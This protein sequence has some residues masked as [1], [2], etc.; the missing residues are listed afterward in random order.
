MVLR[1]SQHGRSGGGPHARAGLSLLEVLVALL[2]ALIG[3]TSILALF[4]VGAKGINQAVRDTRATIIAASAWE[5]IKLRG[6]KNDVLHRHPNPNL[7]GTTGNYFEIPFLE[8][9]ASSFHTERSF[10]V[11]AHKLSLNPDD[12]SNP[13]GTHPYHGDAWADDTPG[14]GLPFLIDPMWVHAV[15]TNVPLETTGSTDLNNNSYRHERQYAITFNDLIGSGG[16]MASLG[17]NAQP[18]PIRVATV[19][20]ACTIRNRNRRRAFVNRLFTSS[21]DIQYLEDTFAI[22]LS[23][24]EVSGAPA[25]QRE[26]RIYQ[27][28]FWA[29]SEGYPMSE[30]ASDNIKRP[31]AN[32]DADYSW[33][34]LYQRGVTDP[35]PAVA[36]TRPG[37][38]EEVRSAVL[39]FYKR[40]LT[41]PYFVAAA[42]MVDNDPRITLRYAPGKQP[43]ITRGA[44]LTELTV[45]GGLTGKLSGTANSGFVP[46]RSSFNFHRVLDYKVDRSQNLMTVTL[47]KAPTG[48]YDSASLALA[49]ASRQQATGYPDPAPGGNVR[50]FPVVIFDGLIEVFSSEGQW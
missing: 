21:G 48:Y 9:S 1:R 2:I 15:K 36:N 26:R 6:Y 16:P 13:T 49:E 50:Y 17:A 12:T 14:D 19:A 45:T 24:R 22:P 40:K 34:F 5:T 28:V 3:I 47:A 18:R 4:P 38:G 35:D 44:I 37:L 29:D 7:D 43:P 41:N 11:D 46:T 20:E 33:A 10:Y 25:Y 42:G 30:A 31:T 27:P 23:S 8:P 32:R 39:V